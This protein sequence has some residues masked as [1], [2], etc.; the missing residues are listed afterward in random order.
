MSATIRRV[1]FAIAGVALLATA[2]SAA[3]GGGGSTATPSSAA[4]TAS[5][6]QITV[7]HTSAGDALAGPNGMTLYF[8]TKD[9]GTTPTCTGSCAGLWPALTVGSGES[10][11]AG[12]G[13]N[14]S[15]LG[16]TTAAAG[17]TQVTYNGHPLYYY[18]GDTAAGQANGQG[19]GGVW[20]IAAPD[21]TMG[22]ASST[23]AGSA[24]AS[25]SASDL[26]Y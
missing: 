14:A 18:A 19:Y 21:G 16:T 15:M 22:G 13:V 10:A 2:C 24:S 26:Q 4:S 6:T 17:G 3:G 12:A 5:G 7:A 23:G 25:P 11:T 20:F 8:F 9:T 1:S